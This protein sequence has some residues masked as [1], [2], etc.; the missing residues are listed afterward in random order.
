MLYKNLHDLISR[1]ASTRDYFLSLPVSVQLALHEHNDYIHTAAQLHNKAY[2]AEKYN[3]A[4]EISK[5]HERK[6]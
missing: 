2:A 4:V 3:H 6:N 5:F 1:S